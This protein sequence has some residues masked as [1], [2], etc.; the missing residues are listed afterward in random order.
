MVGTG[1]ALFRQLQA[2]GPTLVL[3][4]ANENSFQGFV[5][6]LRFRP[7]GRL[8]LTLHPPSTV[9]Q[10]PVPRALSLDAGYLAWRTKRPGV[11][12]FGHVGRG[13]IMVRLRHL[14]LPLDA[15]LTVGLQPS[16]LEALHLPRPATWVPRLYASSAGVSGVAVPDRWRPSPLEYI[17]QVLGNPGLTDAVVRYLSA[18][19]FEFLD[20]DVV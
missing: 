20:F 3:G 13:A 9:P 15:V 8:G 14:G 10:N 19:R 2:E 16:E 11:Q 18:R 7:L 5:R 1:R 4:V 17:A 6:M 12:T